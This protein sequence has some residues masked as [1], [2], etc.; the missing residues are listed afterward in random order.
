MLNRLGPWRDLGYGLAAGSSVPHLSGQGSLA[1]GT[2]VG[3]HVTGAAAD[4]RTTLVL[5]LDVDALP[6]A[7]GTVA[8]TLDLVLPGLSTDPGGR[9]SL[10][11]AWPAGVPAGTRLFFQA[12]VEDDAG[13]QG[14]T[15]SNALEATAP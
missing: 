15:A 6:F 13:P 4:A 11:G 12:W 3:L 1:S 10:W 14:F 2:T 9:L 8:P 7:G 5:G